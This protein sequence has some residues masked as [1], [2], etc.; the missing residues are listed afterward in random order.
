M[1]DLGRKCKGGPVEVD[2]QYTRG[3]RGRL[4][5]SQRGERRMGWDLDEETHESD[6]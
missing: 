4:V 6:M 5:L 3:P 2:L 1:P